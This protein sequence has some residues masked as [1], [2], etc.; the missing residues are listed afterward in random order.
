MI[1]ITGVFELFVKIATAKNI[2][3]EKT[4]GIVSSY[5]KKFDEVRKKAY[6]ALD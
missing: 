4:I 1:L 3:N 5:I 6:G 2:K